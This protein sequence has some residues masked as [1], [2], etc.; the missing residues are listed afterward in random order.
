MCTCLFNIFF[1]FFGYHTSKL[2]PYPPNPL[3]IKCV[4]MFSFM[5]T[6]FI[7]FLY[8]SLVSSIIIYVFQIYLHFYL[9]GYICV[10]LPTYIHK[11]MHDMCVIWTEILFASFIR[12]FVCFCFNFIIWRLICCCFCHLVG[13]EPVF[14]LVFKNIHF[15][16]F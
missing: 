14:F 1:F 3:S 8:L 9:N 10:Y 15:F 11:Y 12:N 4:K 7:L 13:I 2:I 6:I 16:L 5:P